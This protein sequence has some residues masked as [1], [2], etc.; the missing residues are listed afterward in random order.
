MTTATTIDELNPNKPLGSD[1]SSTSDDYH[2]EIRRAILN[3]F[4]QL[5]G[6]TQVS[7]EDLVNL[8]QATDATGV[9]EAGKIVKRNARGNINGSLEGNAFSANHLSTTRRIAGQPFNGTADVVINID[10]LEDV[11]GVT[12]ADILKLVGLATGLSTDSLIT[13]LEE[14]RTR[15]NAIPSVATGDDTTSTDTFITPAR[16][17]SALEFVNL[18]RSNVASANTV[19]RF[20]SDGD[21]ELRSPKEDVTTG[22]GTTVLTLPEDYTNYD[23]LVY[24]IQ[25]AAGGTASDN[26]SG[27]LHVPVLSTWT[28]MSFGTIARSEVDSNR[29]YRGTFST[30]S[31][32]LTIVSTGLSDGSWQ[33][34]TLLRF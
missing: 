30:V 11:V 1:S 33:T 22:I 26:I 2:R 24:S 13:V 31:R 9:D 32:E 12:T 19:P 27:T 20:D 16:L 18:L 8:I 5:V 28:N 6:A 4:P 3:T 34:A 7:V 17:T 15:T 29:G 14:L 23:L 21:L 10:D 25:A